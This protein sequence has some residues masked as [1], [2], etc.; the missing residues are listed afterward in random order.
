MF[1][2]YHAV[3]D[4]WQKIDYD[5]MAKLDRMLALGIVMLG[6]DP[7]APHWNASNPKVKRYADA[8]K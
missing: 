4:E 3:G 8:R 1:P 7:A 2:D 5:N 6:D